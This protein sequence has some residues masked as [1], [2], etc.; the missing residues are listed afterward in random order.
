MKLLIILTIFLNILNS[1]IKLNTKSDNQLETKNN[2][3]LKILSWNI[4]M[5]PNPYGYILKSKERTKLIISKLKSEKKY[6]LILFQEAFTSD[7]REKIYK[8]LNSIYP[9]QIIPKNNDYFSNNSGLWV[10][11]AIPLE[12]INE[13]FFQES[14]GWDRFANKGAKLYQINKN[15]QDFYII[16]T[17]MQANEKSDYSYIRTS[18]INQINDL[19]VGPY[20]KNLIPILLIGDLNVSKSSN[21][22]KY[23]NILNM[24]NGELHGDLN[25][26]CYNNNTNSKE[27]L[28]YILFKSNSF[29]YSTFSRKILK[30]SDL[31]DQ[32]Q[33]HMSD[34]YPIE[35][36]IEW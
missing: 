20:S 13:I 1:N 2:N 30:F 12:L 8:E 5:L 24:K 22:I 32:N 3:K 27:L 17:H 33:T 26:S 16:N 23:L 31:L 35:G 4:K 18:Q 36:I 15:N 19:I 21:L 14:A 6:D 28:D 9:Y 10:I 25:F 34:H 11:S 7:S 29:N